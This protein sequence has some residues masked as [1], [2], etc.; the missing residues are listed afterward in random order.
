MNLINELNSELID[1]ISNIINEEFEIIKSNAKDLIEISKIQKEKLNNFVS[2]NNNNNEDEI[3][4]KND[5]KKNNIKEE[6]IDYKKE[7]KLVYRYYYN[8][9]YPYES[10]NIIFGKKLVENNKDNI[11]LIINNKKMI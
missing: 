2:N 9:Y 11:E 3:N 8:V 10:N 6:N 5:I 7:I 1:S 4:N